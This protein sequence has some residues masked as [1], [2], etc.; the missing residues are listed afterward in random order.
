[1]AEKKLTKQGC[2]KKFMKQYLEDGLAT[3]TIKKKDYIAFKKSVK[4]IELGEGTEAEKLKAVKALFYDT[5]IKSQQVK[6]EKSVHPLY[7]MFNEIEVK[8][9]IEQKEKQLEEKKEEPIEEQ[10]E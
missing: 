1:M 9:D 7:D 6:K 5:F 8:K 4:S 10:K 2:S 3:K